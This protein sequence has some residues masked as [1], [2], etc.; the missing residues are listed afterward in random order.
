MGTLPER[1]PPLTVE[2]TLV[3]ILIA[4]EPITDVDTTAADMLEN[5]DQAINAR[6]ISLVIAEMKDRVPP[7]S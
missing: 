7:R 3:W 1:F 6:G 5:L 4:A 2:P